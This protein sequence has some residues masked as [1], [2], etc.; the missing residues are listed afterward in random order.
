MRISQFSNGL[1]LDISSKYI[2]FGDG[3]RDSPEWGSAYV[4]LPWYMY[5][6]K[7]WSRCYEGCNIK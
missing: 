7:E 3:F 1:V 2:I 6:D 4:I 5:L